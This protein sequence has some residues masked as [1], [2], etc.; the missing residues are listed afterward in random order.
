MSSEFF[1]TIRLTLP[2]EEFHRLPR[3]AAY[4]YELLSGEVWLSPR[5]RWYHALLDLDTFCPPPD[6]DAQENITLRSLNPD[7][8]ARLPRLF[9]AAF[10][11]VQPF[12][13][14]D[15]DERLQA[16]RKCVEQTRTGG[17]GPVIDQACH[18]AVD[19]HSHVCGAILVTLI[20]LVD[21]SDSEASARWEETPPADCI[22]RRLGRPH[23]TWIFVSPFDAGHGIGSALLTASVR[24]LLRMGFNDLA[25][26]FLAGNESSALWHWRNG[27]RLMPHPCSWRELH[28]RWKHSESP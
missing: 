3:N 13:S 26:T 5:P 23:L 6:L 7:E 4:K 27:F 28:R 25:S 22:E 21:L 20:P 14:L 10:R 19:E 15:D 1:R 11:L 2:R 18:V 12:G 17:D 24:S 16:A 9:A 8:W